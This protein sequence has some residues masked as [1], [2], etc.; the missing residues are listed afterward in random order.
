MFEPQRGDT[1]PCPV[2]VILVSC[3]A[4]FRWVVLKARTLKR[5][6]CAAAL[7]LYCIW[8][9][10]PPFPARGFRRSASRVG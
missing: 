1:E 2:E 5:S 9:A 3:S 10:Y 4:A 6:Y 7:R 8:T